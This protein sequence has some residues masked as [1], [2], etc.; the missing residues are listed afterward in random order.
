VSS[1]ILGYFVSCVFC[2]SCLIDCLVGLLAV[3]QIRE[4]GVFA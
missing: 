4:V 3:G 1:F 2:L